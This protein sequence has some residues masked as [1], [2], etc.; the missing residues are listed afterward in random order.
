MELSRRIRVIYVITAFS[1]IALMGGAVYGWPSMRT[2]L[3]RDQILYSSDC[4]GLTQGE[5]CEPQE[6]AFGFIFTVGAWSNQGGR[7][8]VGI[9]LDRF[10]PRITSS[11][12]ALLCC[13]GAVAFALTSST[14]GLAIGL[15]FIGVGGAGMQLSLQSASALFPEN[16]SL[17]MASLSG[18]F[19]AASGIF[20]IM[21]TLHRLAGISRMALL[22]G[23]AVALFVAMVIC[24]IVWPMRPFGISTKTPDSPTVD[25]ASTQVGAPDGFVPLR[26]RSFREQASSPEYRIMLLYFSLVVLQ[27]QFTIGTVGTQFELMG[28]T[29]GNLARIFNLAFSLSW[30]PTP[31]VGH[32]L[33]R[34]GIPRALMV[35]HTIM[36][37]CTICLATE[38]DSLQ[39]IMSALYA[40][41]RVSIWAAF[42][43]FVGNVFGFANYGKLAG[44]GLFVASCV[45]LLQYVLLDLT[46]GA[47]NNNFR[48]V[49]I[50]FVI[51]CV[52]MYPLLFR[53]AFHL[54][55]SGESSKVQKTN[56]L[57]SVSDA[58][59][60][61]DIGKA[62]ADGSDAQDNV[63]V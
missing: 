49:N 36:L 6:L 25:V 42:F 32:M 13:L 11:M 38:V 27:A 21:E 56:E 35:S 23:Y 31:L 26:Q 9:F 39:Y 41:Y 20:L 53:L 51:L 18:A 57:S 17:V 19:Q 7:L 16:R 30:V 47:F 60:E 46:L 50:F 24:S 22:L 2:M 62:V 14:A 44:G 40:M 63:S 29:S 33:D 12:C 37:C 5:T 58:H 34:I 8:F 52:L 28:D 45:S 4:N 55:S 43:S 1:L 61:V 10:G 15:F 3:L 59:S 48:F 54:K